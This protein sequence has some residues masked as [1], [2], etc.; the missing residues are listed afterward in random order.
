MYPIKGCRGISVQSALIVERGLAF[1]R[2]FMLVDDTG[3]FVSQRNAPQLALVETELVEGRLRI[4]T[5]NRD[6]LVLPLQP[7]EGE[8]VT[9]EV[10]GYAA[11][12]VLEPRGTRWF[13]DFLG[14]KVA[15]VYMPDAER[16]P[17]HPVGGRAAGIVSFADGY[18]LLL[19]S[20]ASLDDLN[21]RLVVPVSMRRFRPNIV[22]SGCSPFEEDAFSEM[23]IGQIPCRVAKRCDRCTVVSVD[24]LNGTRG[25]EPLSTLASYRKQDGRVWFGVNLVHGGEGVV[26]IGDGV[27]AP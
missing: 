9:A 20:Q 26:R 16:R 5:A 27:E 3:K 8:A 12:A 13:S 4:S 1:D 11:R 6:E 22:I 15:L 19:V 10:W 7:Q 18:P 21:A 24:P 23:T 2:R 14:R 25:S 17:V